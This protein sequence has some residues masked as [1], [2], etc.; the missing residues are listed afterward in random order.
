LCEWLGL[1]TFHALSNWSP[2]QDLSDNVLLFS[3]TGDGS[4]DGHLPGE[5]FFSPVQEFSC[6]MTPRERGVTYLNPSL[7][8][9]IGE[10][11]TTYS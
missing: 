11:G 7:I 2:F 10:S 8:A 6:E 1:A 5:D 3:L 4:G 9:L